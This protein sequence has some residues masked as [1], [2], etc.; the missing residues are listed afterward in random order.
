MGAISQGQADKLF[1]PHPVI[2]IFQSLPKLHKETFPPPMRPI[3]VGI[4]SMGERMGAWL[5]KLLQ[6][7][8]SITSS[9]IRDTKRMD[10]HGRTAFIGC[11]AMS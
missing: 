11:P 7:L 8:V 10:R 1:V 2:P 6:P 5:D 9:Y 4:G 3:V